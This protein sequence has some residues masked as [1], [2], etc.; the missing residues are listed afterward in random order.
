M[1]AGSATPTTRNSSQQDLY[2]RS[3]NTDQGMHFHTRKV[4]ISKHS[5]AQIKENRSRNAMQLQTSPQQLGT[6]PSR[7][8]TTDQGIQIKACI[9]KHEKYA[10][11]NT[12]MHR[13]RKKDQGMQLQTSPQQRNNSTTRHSSHLTR[14][15][16]GIQ[17][18]RSMNTDQGMQLQTSRILHRS[19]NTDQVQ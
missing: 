9:S 8:Y 3:R 6:V 11:P 17:M 19:R 1:R 14:T 7:I 12:Q 16:Q 10:S 2:N 4:F 13:S 15:D 18:H 5:N